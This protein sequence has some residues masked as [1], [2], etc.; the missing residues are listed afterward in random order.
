MHISLK[1]KDLRL[2]SVQANAILGKAV[3]KRRGVK[4]MVTK[5]TKHVDADAW[6]TVDE[7]AAYVKTHPATIRRAIWR[8]ELRHARVGSRAIRLRRAW[9]DSWLEKRGEP[10]EVGAR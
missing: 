10:V 9:I 4:P 1:T 5:A 2:T 3:V 8:G 7:A 6:Q